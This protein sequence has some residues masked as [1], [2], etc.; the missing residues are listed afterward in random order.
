MSNKNKPFFTK[1]NY[2]NHPVERIIHESQEPI[3][4]VIENTQ[5][6]IEN[7]IEENV[8][9]LDVQN[10]ETIITENRPII[11]HV[12]NCEKLHLRSSASKESESLCK[13]NKGD[14]I[15][16]L[17]SNESEEFYKVCT[18]SGL[19]GYCMKSYIVKD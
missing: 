10:N 1:Q 13:L 18:S 2:N 6:P 12:Y 5:R 3:N 17:D 9:E 19:E 14:E 11:G 4:E 8:V 16:I 15:Q 7:V